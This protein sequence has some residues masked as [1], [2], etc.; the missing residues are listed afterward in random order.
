VE[1]GQ[2]AVKLQEWLRDSV[3]LVLLVLELDQTTVEL[4]VRQNFLLLFDDY[5]IKDSFENDNE[6]DR[7][8]RDDLNQESL[9]VGFDR[10]AVFLLQS[11]KWFMALGRLR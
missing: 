3:W 1:V 2:V 4:E 5:L 10:L 11:Q 9:F 6:T 8:N 7:K